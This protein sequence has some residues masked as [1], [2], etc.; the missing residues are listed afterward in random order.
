[1]EYEID[2]HG[3]TTGEVTRANTIPKPTIGIERELIDVSADNFIEPKDLRLIEA[4]HTVLQPFHMRPKASIN[5][6]AYRTNNNFGVSTK[7]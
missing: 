4:S 7:H 1:M 5:M 6:T 3:N 2:Q